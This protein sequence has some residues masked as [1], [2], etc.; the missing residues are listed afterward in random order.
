MPTDDRLLLVRLEAN[1]KK[2]ESQLAKA[3]ALAIGAADNIDNRFRRSNTSVNDSLGRSSRRL[4]QAGRSQAAYRGQIQNTA[5]QIQDLATQISA[6]TAASV[7]L[8]QQLPQLLGGFGALGAVI[9]AVV[10]IGV[11]LAASFIKT[12]LQ[13]SDLEDKVKELESA[14]KTYEDAARDAIIPTADLRQKYGEATDAA[15]TFITALREIAEVNALTKVDE[16]LSD[17]IGTLST[18]DLGLASELDELG[19]INAELERLARLRLGLSNDDPISVVAQAEFDQINRLRVSLVDLQSELSDLA[20]G[21]IVT[22]RETVAVAAALD[23]VSQA[24]GPQEQAEATARLLEALEAAI[25]PYAELT[26]EGKALFQELNNAGKAVAGIAGGADGATGSI[27]NAAD[28]AARLAENL[29]VSLE[30]ATRLSILE[31]Q[32]AFPGN[33][34]GS[35]GTTATPNAP[36]QTL[37]F[38]ELP[39]NPTKK[40][41]GGDSQRPFF[42]TTQQ[43]IQALE[44]EINL[45]GRTDREVASLRAQYVLLDEA[46]KRGLDLD[47]R[48]IQTG[49]T[50][51][52]EIEAQAAAVGDLTQE[53]QNGQI[54]QDR[55]ESAVDGISTALGNAIA[56]TESLSDAFKSV[57]AQIAS[58]I[59]RSGISRLLTGAL[60]PSLGGGLLSGLFGGFRATGG[61]VQRG[62]IYAV[63]ENT[64]NTEF[65][66]PST[67][68]T[69]LRNDQ[70]VV[71]GDGGTVRVIIEEAP[72]FAAAVRT[73]AQG[74][75]VEVVRSAAANNQ[76]VRAR[77]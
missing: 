67:N 8:G 76:K 68:G 69:I 26:D 41:G 75:A 61:P 10:A 13:A 51:R 36:D 45:I 14:I 29:G 52:Q 17:L 20:E 66:S 34:D 7:A 57:L 9:G 15:R 70:V 25:G 58:D 30:N 49:R 48:N 50:L 40:R 5:F 42:E 63:N 23:A 74:V 59:V 1:T 27:S 64:P 56:G 53:L 77:S 19:G 22:E 71:G 46:K 37:P 73:E 43:Q 16:V 2:L 11:P 12:E 28:Q 33:L 32:G 47:A 38:F 60:T 4:A 72:G 44:R 3:S 65:F 21:A 31:S 35:T 18:A 54:S 6:G 62:K 39:E 24:T 55:F